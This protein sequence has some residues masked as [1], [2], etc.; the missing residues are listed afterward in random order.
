ME[1]QPEISTKPRILI[2]DDEEGIVTILREAFEGDGWTVYT[3]GDGVQALD[4][5]AEEKFDVVLSDLHMPL[6]NGLELVSKVKERK[7]NEQAR[8]CIISGHLDHENLKDITNHGI[9]HV[10]VKPFAPRT[11]IKKIR[12]ACL[13]PSASAATESTKLKLTFDTNIIRC[14]INAVQE[15][16]AFYLQEKAHFGKPYVKMSAA[17]NG[18]LSARIELS[19]YQVLGSVAFSCDPN[20]LKHLAKSIF[21]GQD[22]GLKS[23][24][25]RDLAGEICNQISGKIKM[26]LLENNYHIQIGLPQIMMGRGHQIH[27]SVN[28]PVVNIPMTCKDCSFAI[29]FVMRGDLKASEDKLEDKGLSQ[30]LLMFE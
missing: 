14:V 25:L 6:L 16:T 11:V 20:F 22:P 2:V 19:R 12:E 3:A 30:G 26:R 21:Q 5:I 23:E 28:G 13:M 4:V 29:E 15:V 24:M 8:L 10:V 7:L 1:P 27:H 18:C 17:G 9:S